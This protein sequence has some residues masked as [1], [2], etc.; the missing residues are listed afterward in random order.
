MSSK[1]RR[2]RQNSATGGKAKHG[3]AESA[4]GGKAQPQKKQAEAATGGKAGD[5]GLAHR[6]GDRST[7]TTLHSY[8]RGGRALMRPAAP[9][10]PTPAYE[11]LLGE[12][13]GAA[14]PR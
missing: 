7:L 13:R 12:T 3:Q 1:G 9:K 8:G 14:A 11:S 10:T 4:T 6:K 5:K 2:R